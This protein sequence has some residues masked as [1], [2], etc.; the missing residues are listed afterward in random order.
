MFAET[1]V[2]KV[3]EVAEEFPEDEV[4]E[5]ETGVRS[6]SDG[7]DVDADN[8]DKDDKQDDG[9]DKSADDNQG[10]GGSQDTLRRS[11]R[12]RRPPV[13]YWRPVSLVAHKA[14]TTYLQSIQGQES[15]KWQIAMD[16]EM[17]AIRKNKTWR[18]TDRPASRRVL[19][20]KWVYKV[21]NEVDKNGNNTTRHKA[22][23]CFMGNRQIKGL[24]FNETFAPVAK[25]TTIRCILAMTAANGWELH[26]MD[27]KTAFFNGDLDEEV[28]MEQ[29]DGYVDPTYPEK[30]CRLLQRCMG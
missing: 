16:E 21:K 11:G 4:V 20:G 13:E 8:D 29:P 5:V 6:A 26:Q 17:E 30:V 1:N 25:F 15:A 28:Y 14:P 2:S 10:C 19:K 24:D 7:E 27:V 22:R 9:S 3:A 18:L 23:L 12:A